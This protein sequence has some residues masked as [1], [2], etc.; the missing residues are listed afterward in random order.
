MRDLERARESWQEV[1]QYGSLREL[2]DAVRLNGSS[3]IATRGCRSACW[4]TFLL[5]D[6]LDTTIWPRTLSSSR[7]AYN[8]LRTHFLRHLENPDEL[9]LGYDPLSEETE[10]SVPVSVPREFYTRRRLSCESPRH[11]NRFTK[12]RDF[13]PRSCKMLNAA[14]Q[15]T[16]TFVSRRPSGCSWTS[17]SF[18]PN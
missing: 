6:T 14:C 10:V 13:E 17:S 5:F 11:G 4:K 2:S 18:S 16:C 8:S 15:R 9:A 12:T 7:S 3:S 1:K